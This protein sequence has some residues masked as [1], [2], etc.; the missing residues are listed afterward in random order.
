MHVGQVTILRWCKPPRVEQDVTRDRKRCAHNSTHYR[1]GTHHLDACNVFQ[2]VLHSQRVCTLPGC[3][4]IDGVCTSNSA[5]S[6]RCKIITSS[7][8]SLLM[9]VCTGLLSVCSLP[10]PWSAIMFPCCDSCRCSRCF[11]ETHVVGAPAL[12]ACLE[13][14]P[15][16]ECADV[17]CCRCPCR[18][19][20]GLRRA[21][22]AAALMRTRMCA[23]CTARSSWTAV[24]LAMTR[25]HLCGCWQQPSTE[26][27]RLPG[28]LLKQCR[29]VCCWCASSTS[30]QPVALLI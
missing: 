9:A 23:R 10:V 16:S 13:H 12:P 24:T 4:H 26:L 29:S 3:V 11:V 27:W 19:M 7:I 5:G 1:L 22:C 21:R 14:G 6:L 30:R 18:L 20:A 17:L 2:R 15:V 28:D 25:L 8:D